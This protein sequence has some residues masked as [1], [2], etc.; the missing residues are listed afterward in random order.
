MP[1]PLRGLAIL[2]GVAAA[3]VAGHALLR[4]AG[5]QLTRITVPIARLPQALSGLTVLVISDL[6]VNSP[7]SR[8]L[9]AL[10]QLAGLRPDVLVAAGDLAEA[11]RWVSYVARRLAAI[12]PVFGSFAV[13]GNHD[14]FSWPEPG[15]PA[16]LGETAR[17][18]PAMRAALEQAG[19]HLLENAVAR[20]TI[21]G[22]PLQ[23]VG[24]NDVRAAPDDVERTFADTDG[25]MTTLVVVHSPDGAFELGTHRVDLVVCGHTHGGQIVPPMIGALRTATRCRLPKAHGLMHIDGRP[26]VVS[27]G[28]GT[29]G[30]PF[31]FGVPS[32]AVLIRLIRPDAA[33]A[34]GRAA[35]PAQ[36]STV[37]ARTA[38]PP[39]GHA[40]L[41]S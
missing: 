11:G 32:E 18:L 31:R 4:P 21:R 40:P 41:V 22:A 12:A 28:I 1:K 35:V 19:V 25:S 10:D 16:W 30:V 26:V 15:E 20:L 34:E 9:D 39:P 24:L 27:A 36:G 29:V 2:A 23:V 37:D 38:G 17:P 3:W 7:K 6:H 13:W 33:P 14:H 8:A 5:A